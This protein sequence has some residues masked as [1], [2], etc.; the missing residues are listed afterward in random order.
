M[1]KKISLLFTVL[2]LAFVG[3]VQAYE[4]STKTGSS[5]S[6]TL[7]MNSYSVSGHVVT[8]TDSQRDILD[9]TG[10]IVTVGDMV[11]HSV[12]DVSVNQGGS[13][14]GVSGSSTVYAGMSHGNIEVGGSASVGYESMN[15][16]G[17]DN[18]V[19][20][21]TGTSVVDVDLYDV[22][23]WFPSHVGS[24]TESVHT[25]TWVHL[26]NVDYTQSSGNWSGSSVYI[27]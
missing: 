13:G 10:G 27:K 7:S 23:G 6:A 15:S 12:V 18:S 22:G 14:V 26:A 8:V 25:N 11:K 5:V 16:V 3:S 4:I 9:Y 21:E 1:F 2:S 24:S 17:Y 20:H 19:V